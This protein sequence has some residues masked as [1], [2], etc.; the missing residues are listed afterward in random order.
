MD[1]QTKTTTNEEGSVQT[2]T[3]IKKLIAYTDGSYDKKTKKCSLGVVFINPETGA[4]FEYLK[5]SIDEI[6][7][8]NMRN[9]GGEIKAAEKA[10]TYA[11]DN[12]YDE[13]EIHYD[14][15]GVEDWPTEKWKTNNEYT[16]KY[17]EFYKDASEKIAIQFVHVKAHSHDT[18]NDMADALAKGALGLF[19]K[20]STNLMAMI[21]DFLN[22]GTKNSSEK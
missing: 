2:K 6:G 21:S 19:S 12:H 22:S 11:I 5:T 8:C 4:P 3:K 7:Y 20:N 13:I 10:M 16:A 18:F 15:K 17:V 9:V 1:D 14:Y